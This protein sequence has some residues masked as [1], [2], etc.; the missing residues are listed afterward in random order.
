MTKKI[1]KIPKRPG[2]NIGSNDPNKGYL[3][4]HPHSKSHQKD[5]NVRPYGNRPKKGGASRSVTQ[6]FKDYGK[7]LKRK[8][9]P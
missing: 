5:K 3:R 9:N 1:K 4:Y 7:A 6:V 8:L 2:L